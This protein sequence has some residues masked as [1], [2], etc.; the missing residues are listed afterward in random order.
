MS[1]RPGFSDARR[2]GVFVG[3]VVFML[4]I[5]AV[6]ALAWMVL[7]PRVIPHRPV[8]S[9]VSRPGWAHCTPIR[10]RAH[11]TLSRS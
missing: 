6:A 3:L 5:A 7:L 2:A 8:N 11:S 1:G 9:L 4:V 10:L